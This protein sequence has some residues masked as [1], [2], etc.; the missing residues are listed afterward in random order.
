LAHD[1][2]RLKLP[3]Q[4]LVGEM[5]DQLP[6]HIW[7]DPNTQFLDPA[8]GGGQF[9]LEIRRRL[10][11]AGHSQENVAA[12]IWGCESLTTRVKYVQNWFKSGLV[13]LYVRDPLTHDWGDMK[14][15]V[16]VGNPPFSKVSEGKTAGKRS[17]ELYIQFYKWAVENAR[18]VAMI[19]P[20]TDKKLQ[21]THNTLLRDTANV[22]HHIDPQMFPEISMPMWYVI[23]DKHNNTR[24]DIEW[25]LDG[26]TNNDIPWVKGYINMT[27][28]KNLVGEHLGYDKPK[29]KSDVLIYHKVNITHG[30]VTLYCDEKYISAKGLFP[31]KG[32]AVLMPQT[33]ND[34]GW[35]KTE[36][37]KCN[38]KQ[39]AFNGMNIVF[40]DTKTQGEKLVEFMKTDHFIQAANKVKQGFNNMNLTGLKSMKL[41]K[42]FKDIIS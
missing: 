36:I 40:V 11:A 7:T 13:N 34:D 33:F 17:E 24:A 14:F 5:L 30:L 37:V 20:T 3:I 27:A 26:S 1:T 42:K 39:A 2:F 25:H 15:D 9:V 28:H 6:D 32:W 4:D 41:D 16:I 31:K 22:I 8:F 38:G 18:I 35:S 10:L 21:K 19:I 23:A 12:R 29:K